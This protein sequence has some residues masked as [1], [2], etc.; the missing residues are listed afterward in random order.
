MI[1][2][3]RRHRV[4]LPP[5]RRLPKVAIFVAALTIGGV[6]LASF[7]PAPPPPPEPETPV[8]QDVRELVD[9]RLHLHLKK[10]AVDAER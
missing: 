7:D 5:R 4:T 6:A 3:H 10:A 9:A 8:E 1:S 2:R